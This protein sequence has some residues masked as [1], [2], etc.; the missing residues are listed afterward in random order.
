MKIYETE[1]NDK[2]IDELIRLSAEWAAEDSCYG[3]VQ[4]KTEDIEGNRV[5]LAEEG[6]EA[7]GYLFGHISSS[8]NMWSVMPEGTPFFE[9][10]EIFVTAARRGEGIGSALFRCAE[11]AV[12]GE[13]E[14]MVLST[15]TKNWRAI[16]HFYIDELGMDFWSAR[17]FKKIREGAV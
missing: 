17:L 16:F 14:Y 12:R 6:G 15:A 11:D 1:I 10:E 8:K 5:F 4:N 7:L 13:A 9:V 2:V 3:Y